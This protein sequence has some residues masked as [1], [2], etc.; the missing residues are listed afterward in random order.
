[1]RP[2]CS[3]RSLHGGFRVSGYS[4]A[5]IRSPAL[6]HHS[7]V[8]L[9]AQPAS[10]QCFFLTQMFLW[11][12]SRHGVLAPSTCYQQYFA[13]TIPLESPISAQTIKLT[14]ISSVLTGLTHSL[15]TPPALLPSP[16][17]FR[18]QAPEGGDLS[19]SQPCC[20]SALMA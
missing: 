16:S 11:V 14:C 18:A 17:H 15:V 7:P 4:N 20:L 3:S 2:L 8:V 5:Y 1:M 13:H 9:S 10:A 6:R 19:M 12:F